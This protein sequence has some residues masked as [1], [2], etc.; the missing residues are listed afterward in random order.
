MMQ[1]NLTSKSPNTLLGYAATLATVSRGL[2]RG[3][4]N[5]SAVYQAVKLTW[6]G[7]AG[8]LVL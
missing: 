6:S 8:V 7:W 1:I 3:R 4:E 5:S 2:R